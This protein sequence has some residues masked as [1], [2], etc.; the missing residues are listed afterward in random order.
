MDDIRVEGLKI[1][2]K[3][4]LEKYG[5]DETVNFKTI[6]LEGIKNNSMKGYFTVGEIEL[7]NWYGRKWFLELAN[8]PS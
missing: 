3:S 7:I 5:L 4:W 6:Q 1:K 2:A 8:D